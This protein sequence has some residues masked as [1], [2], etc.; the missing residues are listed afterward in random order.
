M[1]Q[2]DTTSVDYFAQAISWFI[3]FIKGAIESWWFVFVLV[4]ACVFILIGIGFLISALIK[5]G[6]VR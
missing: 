6:V 3:D 5:K 1:E 4:M 2:L